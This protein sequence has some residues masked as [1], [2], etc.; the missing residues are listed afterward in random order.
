MCFEIA[1]SA[2]SESTNALLVCKDI[3]KKNSAVGRC[4]GIFPRIA[5][6]FHAFQR[7]VVISVADS[8]STINI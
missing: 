5:S 4:R 2:D 6:S 3:A 7:A 8:N 1:V